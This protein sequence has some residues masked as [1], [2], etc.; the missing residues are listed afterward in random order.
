MEIYNQKS[1]KSYISIQIVEKSGTRGDE[2]T[3]D[4]DDDDDDDDDVGLN[5]GDDVTRAPASSVGGV[6]HY[7]DD[8]NYDVDNLDDPTTLNRL[9]KYGTLHYNQ[10]DEGSSDV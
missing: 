10:W 6:S 8:V 1:K 3:S 2:G 5:T 9:E 4:D 7:D